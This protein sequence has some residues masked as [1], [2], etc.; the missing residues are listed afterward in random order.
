MLKMEKYK[1]LNIS[2][3]VTLKT[4]AKMIDHAIEFF[5]FINDLLSKNMYATAF[6]KNQLF[7][8]QSIVRIFSISYI[9]FHVIQYN[10]KNYFYLDLKYYGSRCIVL[11][12]SS[13]YFHKERTARKLVARCTYVP[14]LQRT[15]YNRLFTEKYKYILHSY[16][17]KVE[18]EGTET[19]KPLVLYLAFSNAV[20]FR[21][22]CSSP[23][24]NITIILVI[25]K[26]RFTL[27]FNDV[28]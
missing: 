25:S 9:K 11:S 7:Q 8:I 19:P 28:E 21:F 26:A 22:Q 10:T 14:Q 2:S 20:K 18:P 4:Y 16:S 17:E 23:L 24:G 5:H 12:A 3:K 1:F 6:Y 13:K 15:G 27:K